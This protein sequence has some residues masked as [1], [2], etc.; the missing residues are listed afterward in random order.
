MSLHLNL[1]EVVFLHWARTR[2]GYWVIKRKTVKKE[3]AEEHR[4]HAGMVSEQ[5]A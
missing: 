4:G 2:I 3:N 1:G 5:S